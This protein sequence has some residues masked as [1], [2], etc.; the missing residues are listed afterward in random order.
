VQD[1]IEVVEYRVESDP[2]AAGRAVLVKEQL[3]SVAAEGTPPASFVVL[4]DVAAFTVRVLPDRGELLSSWQA[5]TGSG[6]VQVPRAV[7]LQLALE[8]GTDD[9][10]VYRLLVD[11]PMGGP[12]QR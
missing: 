3:P 5:G 8:D 7:E 1:P 4:D 6:S 9:P 2:E 11:L 10:L 12:A